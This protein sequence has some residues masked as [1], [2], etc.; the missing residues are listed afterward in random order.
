[1]DDDIASLEEV[2][3]IKQRPGSDINNQKTAEFKSQ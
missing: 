3:T 1:M 2:G